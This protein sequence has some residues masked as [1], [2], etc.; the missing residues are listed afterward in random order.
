M[1]YYYYSAECSQLGFN[2]GIFGMDEATRIIEDALL[3]TPALLILT[4][5]IWMSETCFQQ[6]M[7]AISTFIEDLEPDIIMLQALLPH[8][9]IFKTLADPVLTILFMRRRSPPFST[10]ALPTL[11]GYHCTLRLA[12]L[13]KYR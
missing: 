3:P 6:R 8:R 4:W 12:S 5:N 13:T 1:G 10:G 11:A 9:V 2:L 7:I